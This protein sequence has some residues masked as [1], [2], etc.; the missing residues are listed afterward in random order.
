VKASLRALELVQ[1][2]NAGGDLRRRLWANTKRFRAE[3]EKTGFTIKPGEHPV[4]PVMLGDA[5]LSQDFAKALMDEGIYVVGFFFPV[6]PKGA[7]RIRV[8]LSAAHSED[9]VTRAL[10]AFT[11]VGRKLGIVK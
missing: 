3:M 8:Q 9:D 10:S 4:V 6:V 7:A 11:R 1:D 5:Q 2:P